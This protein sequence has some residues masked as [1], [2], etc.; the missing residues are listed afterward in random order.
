MSGV[1]GLQL[2]LPIR[3]ISPRP[4]GR[5]KPPLAENIYTSAPGEMFHFI[6]IAIRSI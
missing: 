3:E 6:F 4:D 1:F 5:L 2:E